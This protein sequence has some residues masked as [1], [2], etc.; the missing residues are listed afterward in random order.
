M[1]DI[2]KDEKKVVKSNKVDTKAKKRRSPSRYLREVVGEL[3][4]V[5]WPTKKELVSYSLVVTV[6]IVAA[7]L[8][9]FGMDFVFSNLLELILS[10]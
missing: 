10:I 2:K 5:Q 6:F 8:L 1:A 9:L 4:K 7:S 3:K